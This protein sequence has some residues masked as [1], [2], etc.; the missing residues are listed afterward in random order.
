MTK[1]LTSPQLKVE[2]TREGIDAAKERDSSHC[3]IAEAVKTAFPGAA[4]VSVDLQTI[5]F[6]DPEK[7]LR[8]TYLTPRTAQIALV[9]FDQ[10]RTPEP[11]AFRLGRGQ[12]TR[13]GQQ[14]TA[15]RRLNGQGAGH[16]LTEEEAAKAT[17][18]LTAGASDSAIAKAL[19]CSRSTANRH[20][21]A[22]T[23]AKQTLVGGGHSD[24]GGPQIPDRIGGKTPPVTPFARR[25]QF[26]LR[27][28]ER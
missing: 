15:S 19:G 13:S 11:F 21:N 24:G 7:H 27:A 2:L 10:G 3:M 22:M 16:R 8:Y 17:E 26:G 4:Y 1:K 12:V 9:N 20:R 14:V 18:M 23:L 5:R 6:S 28:L 25:R